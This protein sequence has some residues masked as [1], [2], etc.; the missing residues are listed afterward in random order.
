M[1]LASIADAVVT[2]DTARRIEFMNPVAERLTGW[3][4]AEARERPVAE[5]FAV[6]DETT[7]APIPDPVAHVLA[8]GSV[9]E[10][11]SNVVLLCRGAESIA[12]DYSVAPIRDRAAGR[13]APCSSSRT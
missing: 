4:L 8:N 5:V 13:S 12:I 2:V 3:P 9:I 1:T 10:A 7:G 11:E 6:V